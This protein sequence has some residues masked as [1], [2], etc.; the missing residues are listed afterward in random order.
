MR[1]VGESGS[2]A[3]SSRPVRNEQVR[4]IRIDVPLMQA[5]V[6]LRLALIH[7]VVEHDKPSRTNSCEHALYRREWVIHVVEG[8]GAVRDIETTLRYNIR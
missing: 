8:I 5:R 7:K 3:I 6:V 2:D 4:T 1:R